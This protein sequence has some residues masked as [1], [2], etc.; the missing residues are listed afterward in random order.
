MFK[1]SPFSELTGKSAVTPDVFWVVSR[2]SVNRNAVSVF[3]D[4]LQS[5]NYP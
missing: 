1:L 3:L 2:Q 5:V 4:R